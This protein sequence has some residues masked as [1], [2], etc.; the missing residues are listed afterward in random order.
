MNIFESL[1]NLD[2]S[3]ECFDDIMG[4]V[5]E[6][7]TYAQKKADDAKSRS[8]KYTDR[9]RKVVKAKKENGT[10]DNLTVDKALNKVLANKYAERAE[11]AEKLANKAAYNQERDY[12]SIDDKNEREGRKTWSAWDR[13]HGKDTK[14]A[15]GQ[16]KT[17]Y[18]S[19]LENEFKS[20]NEKISASIARHNKKNK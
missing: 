11:K 6:L 20:P 10:L 13:R 8:K 17:E 1:E 19:Q 18:R 7:V 2:V 9:L 16:E 4:L 14:N 3:E 5:E 15:I 12:N